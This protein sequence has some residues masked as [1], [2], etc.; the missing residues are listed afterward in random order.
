MPAD[1]APVFRFLKKFHEEQ[2]TAF[3]PGSRLGDQGVPT[4]FGT[5]IAVRAEHQHRRFGSLY[6]H[7]PL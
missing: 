6:V 7:A 3:G 2:T 4:F 5:P 1:I